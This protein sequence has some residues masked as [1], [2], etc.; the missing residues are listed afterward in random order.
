[1]SDKPVS[2]HDKKKA[3]S[4]SSESDSDVAEDHGPGV[5]DGKK[6]KFTLKAPMRLMDTLSKSNVGNTPRPNEVEQLFIQGMRKV[7]LQQFQA[8]VRLLTVAVQKAQASVKSP[9]AQ[10]IDLERMGCCCMGLGY[11][12]FLTRQYKRAESMYRKS[13]QYW[14]RIHGKDSPALVGLLGDLA[15]VH[16]AAHNFP[17]AYATLQA[18]AQIVEK[19]NG[20]GAQL[21]SVWCRMG[22]VRVHENNANEAIKCFEQ[23]ISLVAKNTDR[24]S[25][26]AHL[27]AAGLFAKFLTKIEKAEK[28]PHGK[29]AAGDDS[30]D[31]KDVAEGVQKLSV[32]E[33]TTAKSTSSSQTS[34]STSSPPAS[35]AAPATSTAATSAESPPIP[36]LVP[37]TSM[38]KAAR[39]AKLTQLK[40]AVEDLTKK[41]ETDAT[42]AATTSAAAASSSTGSA[43]I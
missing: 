18:C 10:E 30:D 3:D 21:S 22:T 16:M 43:A 23:A 1:M 42:A 4:K 39:A 12:S 17:S 37:P 38:D 35:T 36:R 28:D 34:A 29:A 41:L 24:E 27:N 8:A 25:L 5:A 15:V 31:E 14:S 9:K 33:T 7:Q 32:S 13:L 40:A 26:E 20:Q 19:E 11:L 6:T 2:P